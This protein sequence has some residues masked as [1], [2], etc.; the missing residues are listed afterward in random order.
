M[1]RTLQRLFMLASNKE[2]FFEVFLM[3][4]KRFLSALIFIPLLFVGCIQQ[5]SQTQQQ[6][7]K[8]STEDN[9]FFPVTQ[10]ILGELS[11]IDSLPVTPLKITTVDGK[12]DSVWMKN[13][14]VRSF[15]QPFLHPKIDTSNFKKLFAQRSFLD[16]TIN[17]FTFSYDPV[18]TLPD[19]MQLKRWDVYIDPQKSKVKRIYLVKEIIEKNTATKQTLQLTW[20]AGH[21]CK[22]TTITDQNNQPKIKEEKMIWNFNQ[23]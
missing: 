14:D 19:T 17:A 11:Q 12:Q 23:P 22:I 3:M 20:M 7:A 16:Q 9:T 21:W 13:K 6:P 4:L 5:Q 8:D 10:F 1:L 2:I 18:S 15:A